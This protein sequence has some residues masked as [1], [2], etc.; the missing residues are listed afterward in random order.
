MELVFALIFAAALGY[1][2]QQGR[3]PLR[4]FDL[5]RARNPAAFWLGA[6]LLAGLSLLFLHAGLAPLLP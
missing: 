5:D 6:A 4:F 2:F 1:G 3:I